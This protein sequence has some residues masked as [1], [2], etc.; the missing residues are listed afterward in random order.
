[1]TATTTSASPQ[2]AAGR[3]L[4]LRRA[5]V[6]RGGRFLVRDVTLEVDR[7]GIWC[8]VGPNGSGKTTTLRMLGG[9]WRPTSGAVQLD[10]EDL[11]SLPRRALARRI[12]YVPQESRPAFD[13]T[14]REIVEMGRY[15]FEGRLGLGRQSEPDRQLIDD[16]LRRTDILELAERPVTAVSGGELRRVLIARCLA[17]SAKVLLLDEPTANLDLAHALEVMDL[18]R[19]L[20]RGG[21]AIVIAL[22]DLNAARRFAD[23]VALFDHGRLVAQGPPDQ[24]LDQ[25]RILEVF[26]VESRRIDTGDGDLLVFARRSGGAP[27]TREHHFE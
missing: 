6:E 21:A 3:G 14:V 11:A 7:P 13:F 1:M 23:S 2:D 27:I 17:S 20:A 12:A 9:L 22:H 18:C 16:C 24:V 4:E 26:G 5:G 25:R 19:E 15:P 10:G 8:L